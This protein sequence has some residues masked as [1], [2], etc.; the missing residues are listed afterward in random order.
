MEKERG[1]KKKKYRNTK[2]INVSH[3]SKVT[4]NSLLASIVHELF[5]RK[6]TKLCVIPWTL[7]DPR[8][9]NCCIY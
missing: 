6:S 5:W 7:V 2:R 3:L 8:L 9:T 1:K 4:T